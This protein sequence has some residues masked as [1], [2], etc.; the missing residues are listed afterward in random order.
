MKFSLL[1]SVGN[2][3]II[4]ESDVDLPGQHQV[5]LVTGLKWLHVIQDCVVGL[6]GLAALTI[7]TII[8]YIQTQ[9]SYCEKGRPGTFT[10]SLL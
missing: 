7:R 2:R 10:G 5:Y 4:T 6:A 9:M 1:L 3:S 8:Q